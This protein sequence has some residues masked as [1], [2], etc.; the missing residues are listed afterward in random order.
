MNSTGYSDRN[1]ATAT[2]HSSSTQ[3]AKLHRRLTPEK[4][5]PM[6]SRSN[7]SVNVAMVTMPTTWAAYQFNSG[8]K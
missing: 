2:T 3:A 7:T 4:K 5:T 6:R 1:T 8:W